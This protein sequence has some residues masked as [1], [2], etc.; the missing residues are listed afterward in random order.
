VITIEVS[1]L[2]PKSEQKVE[3]FDTLRI[4][5]ANALPD[6][7]ID[8]TFKVDAAGHVSIGPQYGKVS[9]RGMTEREATRTVYEHLRTIL[10]NPSVT[11][12][13]DEKNEK[14]YI[15]GEHLVRPDGTMGLG[16]F[17]SIHVSGLTLDDA[18]SKIEATLREH[19]SEA[20]IALDVLAYNSKVYYVIE[21]NREGGDRVTRLPITGNETVLDALANVESVRI[22]GDTRIWVARATKYGEQQ[23][24]AVDWDAL[25]SGADTKTNHQL[26]PGDRVFVAQPEGTE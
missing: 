10:R 17:G 12:A 25:V 18:R 20:K 14:L 1:R 2:V 19:F 7:P 21:D 15:E 4:A 3:P 23:K 16:V 26:L 5:V 11:L 6:A 8:G 9:V 22:H 13:I 24:L